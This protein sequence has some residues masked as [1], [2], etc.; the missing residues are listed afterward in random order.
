MGYR[1]NIVLGMNK[2]ALLMLLDKLKETDAHTREDTIDMLSYAD[3]QSG[4][5]DGSILLVWNDTKW[6]ESY[7]SV[8]FLTDFINTIIR[9]TKEN[10]TIGQ[11]PELVFKRIGEDTNDMEEMETSDFNNEFRIYFNSEIN[12]DNNNCDDLPKEFFKKALGEKEEENEN[13]E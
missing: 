9:D 1:S 10:E 6:Y 8:S 4:T 13:D 5:K 2:T 3:D 12:Y 7:P 11:A